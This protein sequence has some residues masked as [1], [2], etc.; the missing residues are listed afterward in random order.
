LHL[1]PLHVDPPDLRL[2]R[3]YLEGSRPALFRATFTNSLTLVYDNNPCLLRLT[4]DLVRVI[5]WNSAASDDLSTSPIGKA[6]YC[7]IMLTGQ[8]GDPDST[9]QEEQD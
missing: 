2:W 5:G 1:Q 3:P 6:M 8:V 4:L 9:N 7:F